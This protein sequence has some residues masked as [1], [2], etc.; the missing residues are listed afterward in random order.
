M[1]Q[2]YQ[3][4]PSYPYGTTGGPSHACQSLS[5]E[6]NIS[7]FQYPLLK[8]DLDFIDGLLPQYPPDCCDT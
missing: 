4:V 8:E 1:E 6:T 3:V 5:V 2:G 7:L